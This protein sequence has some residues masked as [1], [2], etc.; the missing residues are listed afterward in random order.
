VGGTLTE[1]LQRLPA[2]PV[3]LSVWQFDQ[4][5]NFAQVPTTVMVTGTGARTVARSVDLA[6]REARRTVTYFD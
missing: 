4:G 3:C 2:G 1:S 6:P 5:Y